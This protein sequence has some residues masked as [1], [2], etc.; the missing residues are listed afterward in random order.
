MI[1]YSFFWADVLLNKICEGMRWS[2]LLYIKGSGNPARKNEIEIMHEDRNE[3]ERSAVECRS[4]CMISISFWVQ[5]YPYPF[6]YS[7]W[8]EQSYLEQ[9][10]WHIYS[11]ENGILFIIIIIICETAKFYFLFYYLKKIVKLHYSKKHGQS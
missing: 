2:H 5:D 8:D 6:I 3:T 4:E 9:I 7:R 10:F 11:R 1:W